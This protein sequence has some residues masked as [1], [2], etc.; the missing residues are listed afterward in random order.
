MSTLTSNK[1]F[2]SPIGFQLVINRTKYANIDY[3]C[4]GVTLPSV[5]L[6]ETP[7]PYRGVNHAVAGDRLNFS[8][9]S[10]TFNVTEDMENYIETFNWMHDSI[11]ENGIEED[12]E[13]LIYNSHNNVSKRI[14]FSGIFPTSLDSL[15]FNTQNDSLEYLQATVSFKYTS[16]EIK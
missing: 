14:K 4:T 13:L 15:D 2:L 1:N 16:F 7:A 3:F 9:L 5:D 8:E 10:I 11:K 6:A 12:A